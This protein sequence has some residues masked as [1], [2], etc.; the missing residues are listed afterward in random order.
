MAYLDHL[1]KARNARLLAGHRIIKGPRRQH[2]IHRVIDMMDDWRLSPWEHEGATRAGLR[3]ALCE[4]GNGWGPSDAEAAALIEAAL[5]DMGKT[6]RP[7]WLQGQR[8]AV[9]PRENCLGCGNPLGA[10]ELE[11]RDRLCSEQ[12][13]RSV[14][15]YS[16]GLHQLANRRVYSRSWYLLAKSTAPERPCEICEKGYRSPFPQQKF[17]SYECSG[18]AQRN[19]K[20]HLQC[21]HCHGAFV[22]HQATG[23]AQR[24]CSKACR[25]A[26]WEMSEYRCEVCDCQFEARNQA[27]FCGQKCRNVHANEER[28]RTA[29]H[30]DCVIC[31]NAFQSHRGAS[32]CSHSC[33]A[34]LKVR[35]MRKT[36]A[37][38]IVLRP[39][40]ARVFDSIFRKAA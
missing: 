8:E 31:G 37:E 18:E 24:Y 39:L 15:E 6:V 11:R 22:S 10:D 30:V 3:S 1:L 38:V 28:K 4:Q 32:T 26:A 19:P 25:L 12:C 35:N 2:V 40:S 17:C 34:Q 13:R 5:K 20:R 21:A 33:R 9:T 7:T 16:A 36:S 23:K 29:P 27:R 14:A